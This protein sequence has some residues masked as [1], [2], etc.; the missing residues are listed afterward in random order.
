MCFSS[1]HII[2]VVYHRSSG[3]RGAEV[4]YLC[5]PECVETYTVPLQNESN[6]KPSSVNSPPKGEAEILNFML[7]PSLT[8][9]NLPNLLRRHG[10]HLGHLLC[11]WISI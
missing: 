6:L 3:I 4:I 10:A 9:L 1:A 7:L 5:E 11:M 8:T 2:T